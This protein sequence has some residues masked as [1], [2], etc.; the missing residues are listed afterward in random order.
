M[1]F[2]KLHANSLGEQIMIDRATD[3]R[4]VVRSGDL[5]A[6]I[7]LG[8][9]PTKLKGAKL[10]VDQWR[11]DALTEEQKQQIA[12]AGYELGLIPCTVIH[13]PGWVPVVRE[14]LIDDHNAGLDAPASVGV[15][16]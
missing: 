8:I 16:A 7:C 6:E 15:A 13:T 10:L 12:A 14:P 3:G 9:H 4:M 5:I 11:M 1:A 2:F